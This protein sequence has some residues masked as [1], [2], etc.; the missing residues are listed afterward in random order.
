MSEQTI[1]D[2]HF[3][4]E[5][6][7]KYDTPAT[8]RLGKEVVLNI[9]RYKHD[10]LALASA[11]DNADGVN[12]FW[13]GKKVLDFACGTGITSLN[14]AP[15]VGQV[16]GVDISDEMLAVFNHKLQSTNNSKVSAHSIN[17]LEEDDETMAAKA[18]P[19]ELFNFDAVVSALAYH[20]IDDI[21]SASR[22]IYRQLNPKGGWAFV[23]DLAKDTVNVVDKTSPNVPHPTGFSGAELAQTFHA[24]GFV[25]IDSSYSFVVDGI[26][27]TEERI[28]WF[29]KHHALSQD[30]PP[31]ESDKHLSPLAV[32]LNKEIEGIR[33]YDV[34]PQPDNG[35]PPLYMYRMK[36]NVVVGQR[37]E[38]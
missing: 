5:T 17:L 33:V 22:A 26:W 28:S 13:A 29:G 4:A 24:A 8:F 19:D 20:H 15:H 16:V 31:L 32:G 36:F 37:L 11:T 25:N 35:G 10:K 18:G 7:A 27:D 14:L 3:T 1:N 21:D 23:A 38:E 2:K 34:N 30:L 6:A 9:L 12:A